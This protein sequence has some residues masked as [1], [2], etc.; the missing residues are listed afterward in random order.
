MIDEFHLFT[1]VAKLVSEMISPAVNS[2]YKYA[3]DEALYPFNLHDRRFGALAEGATNKS[4]SFIV[5]HF[6]SSW[7]GIDLNQMPHS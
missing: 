3:G 6:S 4:K 7:I 1:N 2:K 5:S